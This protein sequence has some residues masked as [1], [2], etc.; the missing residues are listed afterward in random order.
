MAHVLFSSSSYLYSNTQQEHPAG[1]I[2]LSLFLIAGLCGGLPALVWGLRV[3]YDHY[4]SGGRI[5]ALVIMLLLSDLLEL[6]L[7]PYVVTKLL[8]NDD[9]WDSSWTCRLLTSLWSA[10]VIYGL[11]LRQVVALEAA[12]SFKHPPCSAH[13]FFPSCSFTT[14]IIAFF[15][16]FLCEV[17]GATLLVVLILPLLLM[18]TV[19]SW[20]VTCRAPT[21]I[22]NIPNRTR[23][24]SSTVMAFVTYT[25]ILYGTFTSVCAVTYFGYYW[26]YWRYYW[27]YWGHVWNVFVM[28]V[29]LMSLNV[30]IDPLLCVLVCRRPT[31]LNKPEVNI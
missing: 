4:K 12:L 7:T 3:L 20:I 25:L 29:S 19:T 13:V 30:I 23:R 24:P 1:K 26:G 17:F 11:H 31:D 5:S 15:S 8:Q 21:Q 14:S 18:I 6:Y 16:F 27:E 22:N 9:C 28:G 2:R 10:S